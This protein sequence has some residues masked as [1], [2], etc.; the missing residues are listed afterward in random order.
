MF[1]CE[2]KSR[3]EGKIHHRSHNADLLLPN[4]YFPGCTVSIFGCHASYLCQTNL[5]D[6]ELIQTESN[7]YFKSSWICGE[8]S[9]LRNRFRRSNCVFFNFGTPEFITLV[10]IESLYYLFFRF[11]DIQYCRSGILCSGAVLVSY[12]F[13]QF[14]S[15]VA[16]KLAHKDINLFNWGNGSRFENHEMN[17][18]ISLCISSSA[19]ISPVK[20]CSVD[21]VLSCRNSSTALHTLLVAVVSRIHWAL[22]L[23][24]HQI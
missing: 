11:D 3:D 10:S 23:E 22:A 18:W 4:L 9:N 13:S 7:T 17:F 19:W 16:T 15:P 5:V 8:I 24:H 2:A 1:D 21:W 14:T 20:C 12:I 6:K